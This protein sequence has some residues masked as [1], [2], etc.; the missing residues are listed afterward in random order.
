MNIKDMF[1]N[2]A[3]TNEAR[4]VKQCRDTV[5]DYDGIRKQVDAAEQDA[6]IVHMADVEREQLVSYLFMYDAKD[7][8]SLGGILTQ[9][10][11]HSKHMQRYTQGVARHIII[12]DDAK[13]TQARI[14]QLETE[15]A[16]R[17]VKALLYRENA[18]AYIKML[19]D[20]LEVYADPIKS[21]V[22]FAIPAQ[23]ALARPMPDGFPW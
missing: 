13:A 22:G 12:C 21:G 10:E 19:R 14:Q 3:E 15:L 18:D 9:L 11:V 5:L 4:L 23:E 6:L 1:D 16:D 8:N 2:S 20:A 7:F 17:A